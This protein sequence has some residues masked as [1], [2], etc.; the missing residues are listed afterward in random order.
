M[1]L[2]RTFLTGFWLVL[3]LCGAHTAA[4]QCIAP[5]TPSSDSAAVTQASAR[6]L[7]GLPPS[8]VNGREI[9]ATA[10]WV[11]HAAAM[12]RAWRQT[13]DRQLA[14]WRSFAEREVDAL[15]GARGPLYYPFSGPDFL[16]AHTLF[17]RASRYLLVGL[18]DPGS[19]PRWD[20]MNAAQAA[21]SLAQLRQS[22]AGLM[23]N[24]F[25]R[26]N[27]MKNDLRRGQL[28]GVAP[29]LMAM[30]ALSGFEVRAVDEVHLDATGALCLGAAAVASLGGVRLAL[31]EPGVS[32]LRELVYLR[33]DLSDRALALTPQF[34]RH[35]RALGPGPV[36]LKAASYLMHK[37]YFS[38][39]RNLV[40]E[41]AKLVLQD[42]S[43]IPFQSFGA[44][45]WSSRLYGSY[46]QPIGMFRTWQQPKLRAAYA[47]AARP[48]DTG[49][50]YSHKPGSSN[51][52]LF[53]KRGASLALKLS[54]LR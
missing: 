23:R 3:W 1:N 25:F 22:T 15:G 46:V 2:L 53:D 10:F 16:Y 42:D 35:V 39:S 11:A 51:L 30:A 20:R 9:S 37:P 45:Q 48:L 27:S 34:E 31:A 38:A 18:E 44:E 14:L 12:D 21:A 8:G 5:S 52:Q 4:A 54:T 19:A 26:T 43:G 7:A 17:P 33:V 50:G 36:F 40:L 6:L 24:S 28:Q 41:R 49:I 13:R 47:G 29:V 32:A